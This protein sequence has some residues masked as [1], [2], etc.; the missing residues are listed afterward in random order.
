[1]PAPA[2]LSDGGFVRE[3]G[4][5]L[6][7][8]WVTKTIG[9]SLSLTAFFSVYFQLL[10]HPVFPVTVI[11]F[12]PL[13]RWIGFWPGALPLYVSLWIYVPLA[14]V[15]LRSRSELLSCGIAAVGLSVTGLGIF[16]LWPTAVPAVDFDAIAHPSFA[17]LKTVDASGNACPSLHVA[18]A[19]FTAVRLVPL[20]R[21]MRAGAGVAAANWLWC[22]AIVYS[23]LAT[24]QHVVLD[25]LAGAVL[26]ALVAAPH[27]LRSPVLGN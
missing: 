27:A 19:V 3:A 2:H 12:T 11:P 21:A 9:L 18:F 22:L 13:D 4:A 15:L 10:N 23:T 1:M 24:G 7:A 14:F 20:L 17:F 26:G 8:H 25:V 6:R 5:R 16:F